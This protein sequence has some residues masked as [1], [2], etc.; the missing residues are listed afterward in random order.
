V[1]SVSN[2]GV[3]THGCIR[4]A[5]SHLRSMVQ[6]V[7]AAWQNSAV[8][9]IGSEAQRTMGFRNLG[10]GCNNGQVT[11]R[12]AAAG[13]PLRAPCQ[14]AH[15]RSWEPRVRGAPLAREELRHESARGRRVTSLRSLRASHEGGLLRPSRS[16]KNP[17]C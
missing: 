11:A 1:Q 13:P 10:F 4:A 7:P 15:A 6:I 17:M 9:L 2:I 14:G 8:F 16:A 12:A 5:S 3:T